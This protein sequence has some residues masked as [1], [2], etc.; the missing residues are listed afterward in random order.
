MGDHGLEGWL[1]HL[2]IVPEAAKVQRVRQVPQRQSSAHRSD[3]GEYRRA[4]EDL[5]VQAEGAWADSQDEDEDVL[6]KGRGILQ[7]TEVPSMTDASSR[8]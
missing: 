2:V 4:D 1:V 7:H 3:Q 5:H 6:P 8:T